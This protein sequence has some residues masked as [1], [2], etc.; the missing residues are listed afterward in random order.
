MS[1][2]SPRELNE[3]PK[4]WLGVP[5]ELHKSL[6]SLQERMFPGFKKKLKARNIHCLECDGDSPFEVMVRATEEIKMCVG[7]VGVV[8]NVEYLKLQDI[9]ETVPR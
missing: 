6:G 4:R 3:D 7:Y 2:M 8:G 9:K 1:W 5:H